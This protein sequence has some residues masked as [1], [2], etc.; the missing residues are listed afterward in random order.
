MLL[1]VIVDN[2]GLLLRTQR[3]QAQVTAQRPAN[4]PES[5][6]GF[7]QYLRHNFGIVP[8]IWSRLF[9]M[10]TFLS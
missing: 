6:Q 10:F 3:S 2:V 7:P 5:I 1:E 4:L 9:T 8:H